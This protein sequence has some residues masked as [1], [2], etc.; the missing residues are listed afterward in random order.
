MPTAKLQNIW[1]YGN[2]QFKIAKGTNFDFTD[3]EIMAIQRKI[4]RRSCEK[5]NFLSPIQSL[6][7]IIS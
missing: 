1:Q 4:N 7:R 5:L 3:D 2:S 6:N